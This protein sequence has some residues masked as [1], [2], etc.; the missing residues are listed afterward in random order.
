[1]N[2]ANATKNEGTKHEI[3]IKHIDV[4]QLWNTAIAIGTIVLV[5]DEQ[6]IYDKNYFKC[7]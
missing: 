1:M 4:Y 2:E 5:Y 7:N 3:K 6:S